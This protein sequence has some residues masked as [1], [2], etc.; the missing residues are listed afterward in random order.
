[1]NDTSTLISDIGAIRDS[2]KK[3]LFTDEAKVSHGIVCRLLNALGV[4]ISNPEVLVPE[5]SVG[6][7]R[8]DFALC[9]SPSQP[10]IFIE[11]KKVGQIDEAGEKQLFAYAFEKGVPVVILTDGREWHFF[12]PSGVG[13]Y[14]ERKVCQFDLVESNKDDIIARLNRY[15]NYEAVSTGEA[16]QAIG[17]DYRMIKSLPDTW[18]QLVEQ[19]DDMLLDVVAEK[20]EELYGDK[21]TH[22]QVLDFLKTLKI[23]SPTK[24]ITLPQSAIIKGKTSKKKATRIIVTK[25]DKNVIDY[26][27]ASKTFVEAIE[28]IGIERAALTE[29]GRSFISPVREKYRQ[30]K[31]CGEFFIETSN[32]SQM[33]KSYLESLATELGVSLKVTIVDKAP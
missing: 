13:N 26:R 25:P 33:K 27:K 29:T 20:A 22:D 17:A 14:K 11:V 4:P 30:P 19:P 6:T 28:S 18:K 31:A 12:Y 2:L 1:M 24:E 32:S 21:P 15:L 16:I 7:R 3:G 8:V 23:A 5:F 9:Q 10:V